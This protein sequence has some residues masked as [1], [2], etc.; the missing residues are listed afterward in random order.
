VK[1][2]DVPFEEARA[3][4]I[5]TTPDVVPVID[6]IAVYPGLYVAMGFGCHGFGIGPSAGRAIAVMVIG[7]PPR[8]DLTRFRLRRFRDGGQAKVGPSL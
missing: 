5:D 1:L 8:Y 4:T 6:A 3:G 2:A 7:K